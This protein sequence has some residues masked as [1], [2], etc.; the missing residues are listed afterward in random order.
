MLLTRASSPARS[1]WTRAF[2]SWWWDRI[3][4]RVALDDNWA[5]F[6]LTVGGRVLD[7]EPNFLDR[8]GAIVVP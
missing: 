1:A 2:R 3:K 4:V 5:C 6:V 7:N 8:L